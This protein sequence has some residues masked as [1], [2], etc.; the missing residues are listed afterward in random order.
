[1]YL[2]YIW[3]THMLAFGSADRIV[4]S[5]YANSISKFLGKRSRMNRLSLYKAVGYPGLHLDGVELL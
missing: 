3:P 5:D 1:M 4:I 2:N